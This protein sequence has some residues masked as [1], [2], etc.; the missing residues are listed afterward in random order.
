MSKWQLWVIGK[1]TCQ[2]KRRKWILPVCARADGY[3]RVRLTRGQIGRNYVR[4]LYD[5][6]TV[7]AINIDSIFDIT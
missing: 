3:A 4:Q 6:T 5:L 1:G 7:I 2:Q